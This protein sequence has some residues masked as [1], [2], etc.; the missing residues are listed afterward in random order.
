MDG[1]EG[2]PLKPPGG[3]GDGDQHQDQ[4]DGSQP[5]PFLPDDVLADIFGRL[6]PR[7]VAVSRCVC[8]SW[9]ASIDAR[10]LLGADLLPLSFRGIF[11]HFRMH[12]FP[13]F[14]SRPNPPAAPAFSGKLS[15]LPSAKTAGCVW[16]SSESYS[17]RQKYTIKDH[18][19]GLLLIDE[20]VVNP[21]TRRWDALPP[22][23]PGRIHFIIC[24][25]EGLDDDDTPVPECID[26]YLVFDPTQSAHYQVLRIC[27]MSR[28]VSMDD[29]SEDESECPASSCTLNVLSSRTGCWEERRFVREGPAAG[30]IGKVQARPRSGAVYWR[31]ALYVHCESHFVPRI[32]LSSNTYR[33]IKPPPGY[34]ANRYPVP[35]LQRSEKGVCFVSLDNYLLKVWILEESFGQIEWV[36]KHD[37]DLE[38]VLAHHRLRQVHGSWMLKGINHNS[39]CTHFPEDSKE[40]IGEEKF[41]WS[42]DSDGVLDNEDMV[43]ERTSEECY[44]NNGSDAVF[45]N[46]NM[47]QARSYE[48]CYSNNDSDDVPDNEDVIEDNE[49]ANFEE[50]FESEECYWIDDICEFDLLGLHP[51]KEVLFLCESAKTGLAY[52]LNSSKIECLGDIYPTDYVNYGGYGY[53]RDEM[54]RVKY[55]FMYTP[56]WIE[57]FPRNN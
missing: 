16:R 4:E 37:R 10:R 29:L 30:T 23:P 27:A 3:G 13:A 44:S 17:S 34:D 26:S 22:G 50:N 19:N 36:L 49:K 33:V 56:C 32:S 54:D 2:P 9:C 47:V 38:P 40:D 46:E 11:V 35:C 6:A 55:A 51:Y 41:E 57:E 28:L 42:S 20:Y 25:E 21:A 18:C 39:F 52:H 24:G 53:D 48:E 45:D 8:T 5:A 12:K 15:F 7:W 31:G 1:D 43:Q 14:F